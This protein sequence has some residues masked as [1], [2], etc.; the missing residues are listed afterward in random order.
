MPDGDHVAENPAR[1][2]ETDEK[3]STLTKGLLRIHGRILG[4]F[5]KVNDDSSACHWPLRF[6]HRELSDHHRC[7]DTHHRVSDKALIRGTM[8]LYVAHEEERWQP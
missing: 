2:D 4:M 6:W 1:N 5:A 3:T 7:C 8:P